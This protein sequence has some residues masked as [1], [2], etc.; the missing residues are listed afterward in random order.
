MGVE[1]Y[2]NG[3]NLTLHPDVLEYPKKTVSCFLKQWGV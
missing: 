3:F 2:K 1:K